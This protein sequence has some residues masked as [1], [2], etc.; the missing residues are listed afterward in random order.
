MEKAVTDRRRP[1]SELQDD[2]IA[3]IPGTGEVTLGEIRAS[4]GPCADWEERFSRLWCWIVTH[5]DE[6]PC[7]ADFGL[8]RGKMPGRVRRRYGPPP[9]GREG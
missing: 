2:V 9:M 3:Y 7:L 4:F 1:L 5:P 8:V 6:E